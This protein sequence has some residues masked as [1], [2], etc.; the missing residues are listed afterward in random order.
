MLKHYSMERYGSDIVSRASSRIT[1]VI[2]TYKEVL[3]ALEAVSGTVVELRSAICTENLSRK[4]TDF[5]RCSRSAFML[6]Y[7]LHG[8]KSKLVHYGRMGVLKKLSFFLFVPYSFFT[9][10]VLRGSLEILGMSDI[11]HSL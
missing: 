1:A 2:G 6:S 7:L 5:A 8:V 10:V 9:A 3:V 11:F 4:D